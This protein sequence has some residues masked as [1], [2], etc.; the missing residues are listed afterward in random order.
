M[1]ISKQSLQEN[2]T[3]TVSY[4]NS[5][6]CITTVKYSF[7]NVKAKKKKKNA[8]HVVHKNILYFI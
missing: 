3:K 8:T 1:Q 2:E 4:T 6:S 7:T 5:E